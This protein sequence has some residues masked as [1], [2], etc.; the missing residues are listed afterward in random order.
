MPGIGSRLDRIKSAQSVAELDGVE[1]AAAR[2]YF[3]GLMHFN[4]SDLVWDG[5]KRH[6]AEDP[7]N[8][9]LSFAYTLLMQEVAALIEGVGLDPFLGF[10]HQLDYGR[11]SL[12]LDVIEPFR[13]P[14][15]DRLVLQLVNRHIMG[16][17][18]F[19]KRDDRQG[20][21]LKPDA[22]IKFFECHEKWMLHKPLDQPC[23]R[24]R[25]RHETE[26]LSV[27]IRD[28]SPFIAYRFD[29]EVGEEE[30]FTSSVTI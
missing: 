16:M 20:L 18:D 10:L 4:K 29:H 27:A 22:L 14:I 28:E 8:A 19:V 7:L 21:F 3:Q 11:P 5:R 2:E 1:G 24:E 23:F 6:P 26:R 15:A 17:D 12:A 13:H 30:C 25:L 9:L